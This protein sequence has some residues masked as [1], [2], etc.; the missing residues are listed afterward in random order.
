MIKLNLD[1]LIEGSK[2][3]QTTKIVIL[4]REFK[5]INII[6][7]CGFMYLEVPKSLTTALL[8]LETFR[9]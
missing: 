2:I 6:L 4:M 1:K 5:N 9:I 7:I 3:S 8:W